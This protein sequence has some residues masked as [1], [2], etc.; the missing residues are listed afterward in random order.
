MAFAATSIRQR[1]HRNSG[2][3]PRG[4]L[5]GTDIAKVIGGRTTATK[6]G[7]TAD[8]GSVFAIGS[9]ALGLAI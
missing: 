4:V 3:S 6:Y 2:R 5:F 7:R 9:F 1:R 8:S